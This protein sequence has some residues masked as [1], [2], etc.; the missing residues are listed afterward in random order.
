MYNKAKTLNC[1]ISDYE[2]KLAMKE[3]WDDFSHEWTYSSTE[4]KLINLA[5]FV[6]QG[7]DL[8][9]VLNRYAENRDLSY[10]TRIQMCVFYYIET[11][12]SG[13]NF[14]F[15][16]PI[17][18][19]IKR[20]DKEELVQLLSEELK[21]CVIEIEDF[22]A[23]LNKVTYWKITDKYRNNDDILDT[24]ERKHWSKFPNEN[25]SLY[26]DKSKRWDFRY[27]YCLW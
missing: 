3:Y 19:R 16:S 2:N 9:I 22:D 24:I 14:K 10:R 20:L 4:T 8:N 5:K 18:D 27:D 21:R 6:K 1:S 25:F 23:N 7:G 11:L 17:I 13:D 12:I 15:G 26:L